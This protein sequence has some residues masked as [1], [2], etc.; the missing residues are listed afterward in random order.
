MKPDK[1][2]RT[3]TDINFENDVLQAAVPALVAFGTTWSGLYHIM[4]PCLHVLA[5]EFAP[6]AL[7]GRI[8]AEANPE[9]TGRFG[10]Q[11]IPTLLFFDKGEV[12][13]HVFGTAPRAELR[14]R[15]TQLL[16]A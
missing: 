9:T 2:L 3:L 4:T 11:S 1:P 12:V 16:P 7:V 6:R 15:L 14:A 10:I 13:D 5:K 8:D